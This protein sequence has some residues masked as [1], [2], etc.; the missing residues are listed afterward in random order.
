M[1]PAVSADSFRLSPPEWL[2]GLPAI[3]RS[4]GF[5]NLSGMLAQRTVQTRI[6]VVIPCSETASSPPRQLRRST[7]MSLWRSSSSTTPRR[8]TRRRFGTQNLVR[9]VPQR[10]DPYRVAYEATASFDRRSAQPLR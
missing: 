4:R 1:V 7:R 5:G 9:A 6:S 2:Q 8:T 3:R 10:L